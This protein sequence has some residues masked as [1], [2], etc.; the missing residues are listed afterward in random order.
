MKCAIICSGTSLREQNL[1]E[2][3]VPKIGINWSY[4]ATQSDIHVITSGA[5]VSSFGGRLEQLTPDALRF[6][7]ARCYGAFTPKRMAIYMGRAFHEGVKIPVL[8]EDYDIYE[9]GWVLAGGAPCALQVAISLGYT[10]I[11]FFGLDLLS[12]GEDHH[13]YR[14]KYCDWPKAKFDFS[15]VIQS[16]FLDQIKPQLAERGIVVTNAGL[17]DIFPKVES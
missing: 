5:F 10:E 17:S 12:L 8:P 11:K 15:W 9:H 14:E 1:E 13:F 3:D 7:A 16:S 6:S 2:I 4:K